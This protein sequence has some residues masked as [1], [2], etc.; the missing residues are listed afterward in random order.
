MDGG[1]PAKVV[2]RSRLLPIPVHGM[3]ISTTTVAPS[4]GVDCGS[5][6]CA[7]SKAR[8]MWWCAQRVP[9]AI[10]PE[11][12]DCYLTRVSRRRNAPR[13]CT[14]GGS[15]W[16]TRLFCFFAAAMIGSYASIFQVDLDLRLQ[17]SVLTLR[18]QTLFGAVTFVILGVV[19]VV[20][21]LRIT[22]W[23][24]DR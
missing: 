19:A 24:S 21:E 1:K 13:F 10:R 6:N 3:R 5:L 20:G 15:P 12:C 23:F 9:A 16:T 11:S 4:P 8:S 14:I 2:S 7:S 17:A 22:R 18:F